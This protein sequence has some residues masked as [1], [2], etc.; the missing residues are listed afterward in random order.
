MRV[1]YSSSLFVFDFASYITHAHPRPSSAALSPDVVL[2]AGA[3]M[4]GTRSCLPSW[5]HQL[6]HTSDSHGRSLL[7]ASSGGRSS[8]QTAINPLPSRLTIGLRPV[9]PADEIVVDQIASPPGDQTPS[10]A[11]ILPSVSSDQA[12]ARLLL[13]VACRSTS[14]ERAGRLVRRRSGPAG[15]PIALIRRR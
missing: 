4:R 11:C 15:S 3:S 1:T 5:F 14:C 8:I 2:L 9:F 6:A 12:S 7:L 10:F 13:A